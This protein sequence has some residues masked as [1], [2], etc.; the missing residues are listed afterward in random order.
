MISK[1]VGIGV[2]TLAVLAPTVA[3]AAPP[4][5]RQIRDRIEDRR[6]RRR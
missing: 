6:D 1:L 4:Q 2:L 5:R 3:S